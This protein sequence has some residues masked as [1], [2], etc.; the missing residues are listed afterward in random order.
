MR[1]AVGGTERA[2]RRVDWW[3]IGLLGL[4]VVVR[5]GYVIATRHYV[6]RADSADYQRIAA[7]IA[8]GHGF[9]PSVI[10]PGGGPSAFRPPLYPGFLGA[11]YTVVGVH[12]Q[13]VP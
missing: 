11:L 4:A 7:S 6:P 8:H 10:A 2:V 9:G 13:L 1:R 5:V 12:V 3:W